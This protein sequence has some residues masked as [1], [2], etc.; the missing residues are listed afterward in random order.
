MSSVKCISIVN[1]RLVS[2]RDALC[3]TAPRQLTAR[4]V[5]LIARLRDFAPYAV[6]V[7]PGGS[8]MALLWWVYRRQVTRG[9]SV[10]ESS[11]A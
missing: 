9:G 8:V 10:V 5:A 6:I 11:T 4:A 3:G 2:G 7:L 1:A